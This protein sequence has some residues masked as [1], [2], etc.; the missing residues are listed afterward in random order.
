MII[1]CFT[2]WGELKFVGQ[3]KPLP[4]AGAPGPV[5]LKFVPYSSWLPPAPK[6]AEGRCTPIVQPF[7][8]GSIV[9]VPAPTAGPVARLAQPSALN[10]AMQSN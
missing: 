2:G 1:S 9:N 4:T 8:T 5:G 3:N 7:Q 10:F 6:R